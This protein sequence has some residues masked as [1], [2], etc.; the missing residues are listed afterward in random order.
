MQYFKFNINTQPLLDEAVKIKQ[1]LAMIAEKQQAMQ[2][3]SSPPPRRL[4]EG[5]I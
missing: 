4:R 3:P 2:G 5:Y 1:Q